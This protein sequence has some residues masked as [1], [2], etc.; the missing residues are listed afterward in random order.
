M[1]SA[2]AAW[3]LADTVDMLTGVEVS[4]VLDKMVR[5]FS[6]CLVNSLTLTLSQRERGFARLYRYGSDPFASIKHSALVLSQ[7]E[8]GNGLLCS[9]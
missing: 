9:I 2:Q 1:S 4:D 8:E 7:R 5:S 6:S 3:T